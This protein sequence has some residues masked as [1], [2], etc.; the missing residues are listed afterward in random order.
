MD[1]KV[2]K[3]LHSLLD[4]GYFMYTRFSLKS[5]HLTGK[6][7]IVPAGERLCWTICGMSWFVIQNSILKTCDSKLH[8][9][10]LKRHLPGCHS[11]LKVER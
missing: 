4:F 2:S 6:D 1:P 5:S 3:S 9:E 10:N 7:L 11:E 8:L